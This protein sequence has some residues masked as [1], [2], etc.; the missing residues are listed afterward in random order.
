MGDQPEALAA[1]TL[2]ERLYARGLVDR[3]DKAVHSRD[4]AALR[5]ILIDVEVADV[6]RPMGQLL[7]SPPENRL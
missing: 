3:F 4:R 1:M 5:T 6:E 2:N 7:N